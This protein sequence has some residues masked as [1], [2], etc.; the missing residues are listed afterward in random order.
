MLKDALLHMERTLSFTSFAND[1]RRW[2][3]ITTEF[4][5]RLARFAE[6]LLASICTSMPARILAESH[7]EMLIS[8]RPTVGVAEFRLRPSNSCYAKRDRRL[9]WPADAGGPD[10][11]GLAVSLALCRGF[12]AVGDATPPFLALDFE[13]R[14]AHER[15]CFALMLRDHRHLAELLVTRGGAAL[16]TKGVFANVKA[17]EY[18]STFEQLLLYFENAV[19]P[20]NQFALQCKFGITAKERDIAHALLIAAAL[21]DATMGYCLPQPQRE[22]ILDHARTAM[23][24]PGRWESGSW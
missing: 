2:P 18:V 14:G 8:R 4:A 13:I 20:E 12:A 9:P 23:G 11:V 6:S 7:Q 3:Q 1:Q 15:A 21:Y 16:F 24:P 10:A 17:A 22:R 19:D 5:G